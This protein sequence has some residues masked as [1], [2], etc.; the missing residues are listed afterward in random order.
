MPVRIVT[1]KRITGLAV[2]GVFLLVLEDIDAEGDDINSFPLADEEDAKFF[3]G[4]V[5]IDV[6]RLFLSL[7]DFREQIVSALERDLQEAHERI[8]ALEKSVNAL[9]YAS[10]MPHIDPQERYADTINRPRR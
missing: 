8:E 9:L 6:E 3:L 7:A 5:G 2:Q 4:D 10:R 1:E